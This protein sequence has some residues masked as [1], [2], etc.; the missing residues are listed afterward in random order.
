MKESS[1]RILK[2]LAILFLSISAI[3]AVAIFGPV[4]A[5]HA[6]GALI[7]SFL[8]YS[9]NFLF[10][11]TGL[12]TM[13]AGLICMFLYMAG[14]PISQDAM[15]KVANMRY[16][17]EKERYNAGM[18][19]SPDYTPKKSDLVTQGNYYLKIWT[20]YAACVAIAFLLIWSQTMTQNLAALYTLAGLIIALLPA[21]YLQIRFG[22]IARMVAGYPG[23]QRISLF[24]F[25]STTQSSRGGPFGVA[26]SILIVLG[27]A[28]LVV[29]SAY[30]IEAYYLFT[31][32]LPVL[33]LAVL[34]TL[35]ITYA[36]FRLRGD[37]TQGSVTPM[38]VSTRPVKPLIRYAILAEIAALLILYAYTAIMAVNSGTDDPPIL[39]YRDNPLMVI[40]PVILI[41]TL[42]YAHREGKRP[43]RAGNSPDNSR[44]PA[45]AGPV[46]PSQKKK[47]HWYAKVAFAVFMAITLACASE[48]YQAAA[49]SYTRE[50][51]VRLLYS[52]NFLFMAFGIMALVM[53]VCCLLF[54]WESDASIAARKE[55]LVQDATKRYDER[56]EPYNEQYNV[57]MH[58]TPDHIPDRMELVNRGNFY[59]NVWTL[60]SA[61]AGTILL[62]IW[63]VT[64]TEN[65]AAQYTLIGTAL[66][67]F[68]ATLLH[69]R[70]T[71]TAARAIGYEGI[72]E[73]NAGGVLDLIGLHSR[74][75]DGSF[76]RLFTVYI[77]TILFVGTLY[78][79]LTSYDL[80]TT[81]LFV[82]IPGLLIALGLTYISYRLRA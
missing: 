22:R 57:W 5:P 40:L 63:S 30:Q 19:L 77:V 14:D 79:H 82:N 31:T 11:A 53:A 41:L 12:M 43:D 34:T 48:L 45:A 23:T 47:L 21:I 7:R 80:L 17:I 13:C 66:A 16:G 67:L 78:Y 29:M 39:I 3:C 51:F 71:E 60:Y 2:A 4:T 46:A 62:L 35:G 10:L 81:Y 18:H 24:S 55:A 56:I 52:E 69:K 20:L 73:D 8:P 61:C 70:Y 58:L 54:F 37:G 42:Y 44:T 75:P 68:P 36:L 59:L 27:V 28:I 6:P 64:I 33:I 25:L 38:T 1:I 74:G 72:T 50:T 15:V 32:Y 9:A 49:G 65:P 76:M 26:L